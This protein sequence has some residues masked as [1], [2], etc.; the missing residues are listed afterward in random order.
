MTAVDVAAPARPKIKNLWVY[1]PMLALAAVVYTVNL[2][3]S[4]DF[5]L[6]EVMYTIAGHH[7]AGA[8]SVSWGSQPVAVHPP[9]YFVLL[10]AWQLITGTAQGPT[11]DALFA[12][13][14]LGALASVAT[15]GVAGLTADRLTRRKSLVVAAMAFVMLDGFLV[16][17]GRTALIE[18]VAVLAGMLVVWLA[19]RLRSASPSLY[20]GAV[21]VAS[22]C[23]LLI[24]EP[25]L[26]TVLVPVVAA[27]L[28]R[29]WAQLRRAGAAVLLGAAVWAVFPLWALTGGTIR[30]WWA[31]HDTSLR[32]LSGTLQVSGLNRPGVSSAG[33]FEDTFRTYASGYAIFLLGAAGLVFLAYR[34][35]LFH[36]RALSAEPAALVALGGVSYA[37]LAYCVLLGQANEQLTAYTAVP[38]ALL[39]ALAWGA[40]PPKV[41]LVAGAVT[42]LAGVLAWT[43]N[44]ALAHDDATVRMG[45]YLAENRPCERVNATGNALRWAPAL[46]ANEVR[47]FA[48]G[49]E[50]RNAGVGLFL[51]SPKDS[52]LY[53]GNSSPGLDAYV[54]HEGVRLADFASRRYERIEL[55]SVGTSLRGCASALPPA[56]PAASAARFLLLLGGMVV[57]VA[58]GMAVLIRRERP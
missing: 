6:D 7:V 54:R 39:C 50:A 58:G 14:W 31:E 21:G 48:D 25:L 28:E 11:L 12:A 17:F 37:F 33:V 49:R 9:L 47:G 46:P 44:V 36:R 1:G 4:L 57:I 19:L 55:W 5:D 29:D 18:P 38:S 32:R 13:R 45:R 3:G 26:F 23:A 16:R 34:S 24:K 10:G 20:I 15:V 51:L 42:L 52:R 27:A 8:G 41:V 56:S 35:G 2:R 43:A 22:G 40:R 30:W 53:Y